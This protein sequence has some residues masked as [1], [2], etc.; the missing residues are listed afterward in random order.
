MTLWAQADDPRSEV[1]AQLV[2]QQLQGVGVQAILKLDERSL[3]LT[4]LFMQEYDLAVAHFNIPLDP[5]QHYFWSST[6]KKPGFGLN[7]TA[8]ANPAV[9]AALT[10]GNRAARCDSQ[11]RAAAVGDLAR[12]LASDLPGS[13]EVG[14][15]FL[16]GV[17]PARLDLTLSL[18]GTSERARGEHASRQTR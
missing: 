10:A 13:P 9:D 4:R 5:D 17:D 2:R 14:R 7:V 11:A 16:R 12:Q 3:Y 1:V 8:Y 15:P 18:R 6:E